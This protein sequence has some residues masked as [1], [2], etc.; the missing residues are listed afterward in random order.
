M[1]MLLFVLLCIF[2]VKCFGG[3]LAKFN[4]AV[5]YRPNYTNYSYSIGLALLKKPLNCLKSAPLIYS[6][7]VAVMITF[8]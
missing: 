5:I 2:L 4:L 7:C 3:S 1:Q 6:C 8:K